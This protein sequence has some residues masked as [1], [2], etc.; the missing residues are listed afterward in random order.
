MYNFYGRFIHHSAATLAPLNDMLKGMRRNGSLNW[1]TATSHAFESAREALA[2]AC[3][4][5]HPMPDAPLQVM[6]DASNVAAGGVIHQLVDDEWQPIAFFSKKFQP[7]ETRYST[8]DR[9]LLAIYLTT[10]HFQ[11]FLEGRPFFIATDHKPLTFALSSSQETGNLRRQRH[12]AYI[13]E[14]TDDIRYVPGIHN[15]PADALSRIAAVT[16]PH[17]PATQLPAPVDFSKLAAAQSDEPELA[18]QHSL[19]LERRTLPSCAT[20]VLCDISKGSPRPWLPAP[21]RRAAFD[22]LHSLSHPGIRASRKLVAERFV[23]PGM[24]GDVSRWARTCL[25]CQRS[26]I[27]R[28]TIS[29]VGKF[30]TPDARFRHVHVDIVGPLPP[31]NGCTH[32]LTVIDRF[33]RWPEVIPLRET[34]AQ[35]VASAFLLNWVARFGVPS[36][37]TTD[38]GGQFT[39]TT[40][41]QMAQS[42]GFKHSTTTAYHPSANGMVER[43]H[44]QLKAALRAHVDQLHWCAHLPMVLL[45]IRSAIKEDIG[46][47]SSDLV[48]GTALRLPGTALEDAPATSGGEELGAFARELT[49]SM[50]TLKPVSPRAPLN[51]HSFVSRDLS[52]STHVFIRQDAIRPTLSLIRMMDP[53]V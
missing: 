21:F 7:R 40:W 22:S 17:L 11:F 19:Q 13:S 44:R 16:A 6:T 39:S 53:I 36:I 47:C 43:V 51:Q 8:F 12:L 18:S 15:A 9:E 49:Q 3:L 1:S 32:L 30:S 31:S 45:G 42:L 24:N 10:K 2:K 33:T 25:A 34:G 41:K 27:V 28:H 14:L 46:C 4:L 52:S 38:R 20:P 48:Y 29:P 35:A 23:W 5:H 37:V 26:K 50:A